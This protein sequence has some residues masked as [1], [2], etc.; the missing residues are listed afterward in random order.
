MVL[1]GF[2]NFLCQHRQS[3]L[4]SFYMLFADLLIQEFFFDPVNCFYGSLKIIAGEKELCIGA[5][6]KLN[7]DLFYISAHNG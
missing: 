3:L 5:V 1:V 2:N 7:I 4:Q 6:M